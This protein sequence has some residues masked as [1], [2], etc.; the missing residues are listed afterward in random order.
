MN[1]TLILVTA[2]FVLA[3]SAVAQSANPENQNAG[4]AMTKACTAEYRTHCTGS[5]PSPPIAAACL[6]QYYVNLSKGCQVALD[7][8]AHPGQGSNDE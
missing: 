3:Q 4:Q 6:S 5:N 2:S 1:R 8:Y 7:A